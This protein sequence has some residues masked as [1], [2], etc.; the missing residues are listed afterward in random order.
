MQEPA[1]ALTHFETSLSHF[2][3]G[4]DTRKSMSFKNTPTFLKAA[5]VA[6]FVLL[7][8]SSL[9]AE[10]FSV[11]FT[12][13]AAPKGTGNIQALP[14]PVRIIS[15]ASFKAAVRTGF[16]D[17]NQY[18]NFVPLVSVTEGQE[19][20]SQDFQAL[21]DVPPN[22]TANDRN[23]RLA[24][25]LERRTQNILS[26]RLELKAN[27]KRGR[28]FYVELG[29]FNVLAEVKETRLRKFDTPSKGTVIEV[30][31]P[32]V[33]FPTSDRETSVR[34]RFFKYNYQLVAGSDSVPSSQLNNAGNYFKSILLREENGKLVAGSDN[35]KVAPRKAFVFSTCAE[36]K[37]LGA[38]NTKPVLNYDSNCWVYDLKQM[39]EVLPL[40]GEDH[41]KAG[42]YVVVRE[43]TDTDGKSKA[44]VYT[45]I[46]T[47]KNS[48]ISLPEVSAWNA[49]AE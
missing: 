25:I 35:P 1:T 16:G 8:N 24:K 7:A 22:E 13:G 20:N 19:D 3:A 28:E 45:Q 40:T 44:R 27:L 26:N 33:K 37:D 9:Q 15:E 46:D 48:F 38:P 31:V 32:V 10:S 11:R 47:F 14:T 30:V 43:A 23:A 36:F 34:Y 41:S 39:N 12:F 2:F 42:T 5:F 49:L 17:P 4:H 6:L 29:G 18:L 21:Y